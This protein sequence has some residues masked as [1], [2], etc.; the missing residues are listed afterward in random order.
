MAGQEPQSSADGTRRGRLGRAARAVKSAVIDRSNP[1]LL[2]V[3]GMACFGLVTLGVGI[4]STISTA[5]LDQ[6]T[7][8][9]ALVE[10]EAGRYAEAR[11][12]AQTM[13]DQDTVPTSELGGPP[14][15]FGVIALHEAEHT[16]DEKGKR[17]LYL[18]SSRYLEKARDLGFPPGAR[19]EGMFYLGVSLYHCGRYDDCLPV[20][21]H[22]LEL[23]IGQRSEVY[24]LLA[25]AQLRRANP[26]FTLALEWNRRYLEQTDLA[27]EEIETG[28]LQQCDVLLNMN[29]R[30]AAEE[31]LAQV[32]ADSARRA[33]GH[34]A[35][36]PHP[37]AR[38]SG[39]AGRS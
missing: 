6:G 2:V 39:G 19:A 12:L 26:D 11:E 35:A 23:D 37:I 28:Y 38:R 17:K 16:W 20:L 13:V 10:L 33:R 15:I 21:E 22:A 31:A 7:L 29:D 34:G 3:G 5:P 30:A 27:P 8:N 1:V 14:Y 32:P 18:L 24:R 36:G 4:Y 25:E 9:K